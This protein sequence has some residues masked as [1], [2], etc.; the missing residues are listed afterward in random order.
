LASSCEVMN[1]LLAVSFGVSLTALSVG[2][3][4]V[5]GK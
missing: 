5:R 3:V 1:K 4:A 2:F